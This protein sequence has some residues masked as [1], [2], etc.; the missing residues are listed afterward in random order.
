MDWCFP[1]DPVCVPCNAGGLERALAGMLLDWKPD[2]EAFH[3][4]AIAFLEAAGE[5]SMQKV[6]CFLNHAPV[7]P[8][9]GDL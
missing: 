3:Q 2:R 9:P 5:Q 7:L 4:Q 6:S 8:F 1:F